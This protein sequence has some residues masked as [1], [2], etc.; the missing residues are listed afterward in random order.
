MLPFMLFLGAVM[1]AL[2]VFDSMTD[3]LMPLTVASAVCLALTLAIGAWT[4][5]RRG[6]V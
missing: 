1:V 4:M 5:T 3:K 6:K 2:G